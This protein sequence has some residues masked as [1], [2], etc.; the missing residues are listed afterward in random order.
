MSNHNTTRFLLGALL[1]FGVMGADQRALAQ[2]WIDLQRYSL[3]PIQ[4]TMSFQDSFVSAD[5]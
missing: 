1:A 3:L 5:A 4:G 2:T